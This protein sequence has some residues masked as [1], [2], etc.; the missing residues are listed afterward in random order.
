M[1][2]N[3]S[4]LV[5]FLFAYTAISAGKELK[6]PVSAIP[7]SLKYNAKAVVRN[8]EEVFEIKSIS[9]AIYTVS[10]ALTILNENALDDAVFIQPYSQKLQ[11]VH[12]IRGT[13]YNQM[14][15]KTETLKQDDI[16]DHSYI[17]GYSLYEDSRVKFFRPRTM[18][19]P[20]TVE[21]SYVI[22]YD[23]L[24]NYPVWQP[25]NDYNV[26]V[27]KSTLSIICPNALTFRYLE[28]NLTDKAEITKNSD[29]TI[30][31]WYVKNLTALSEQPY[32]VPMSEFTPF[33]MAAPNDFEIE[34]Y[35][36]NLNSWHD[37]GYWLKNLNK[38]RDV[39][40]ENTIG[41][42]RDLIKDCTT[43]YEKAKRI[44][45][46]MQNKTRY[47]SIQIG[48]GGWQPFE[49]ATVD[50]LG[51]GD[52][53]ALS[54]YMNAL[55]SAAGIK[56]YYT[57]IE[58]G[59]NACPVF[60]DFPNNHFNHAI[61]CLPLQNDTVW[62][63][64]TNPYYPFGYIGSFTDD[65]D[66]LVVTENGGRL[67][68]TKVYTL[69]DNRLERNLSLR[70]DQSG[71][72]IMLSNAKYNGVFYKDKLYFYLAGTD[73][74]KKMILNEINLPGAVLNKFNYQDI[75][76]AAPVIAEDLEIEVPR[77]AT[78]SG[79]RML[80]SVMPFYRQGNAPKKVSQRR[81]D[82]LIRRSTVHCDTVTIAVPEGYTIESVP[83]EISVDSR[84]GSYSLKAINNGDNVI[85]I[86]RLEMK[87]GRHAQ[88]TYTELIEF[89]KK[90]S[91]ADNT[92]ISFLKS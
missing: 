49:A 41:I 38:G 43:D 78:V 6:Y 57:L 8:Y 18:T 28:K 39:L 84:F 60:S 91:L 80:I 32:S 45:E 27:E 12:S 11:K 2:R 72:A 90:V 67:V 92:K 5:L 81:S 51:Y 89:F 29:K 79:N 26:S 7:E 85:C 58:A 77:Y 47:V 17:S 56:S 10:Y 23:G 74:K 14:G 22:E 55:L 76:H 65:R 53:K 59:E 42:I 24:L 69:S 15:E 44:Y 35:K 9:N 87:K 62:L 4:L 37:F 68:H 13:I 1:I 70:L 86:R 64:C 36:G 50:R 54:N 19:C 61:L 66:A 16:I 30:Y 83:S 48:I 46:Y 52:C 82:V 3:F 20:F 31:T 34:G 21:Y 71:N 33:V 73:D 63:E 40:P 25:L 88:E 75:R